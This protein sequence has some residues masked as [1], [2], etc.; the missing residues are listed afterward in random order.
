MIAAASR[1]PATAIGYIERAAA[2]SPSTLARKRSGRSKGDLTAHIDIKRKD[3][4][5]DLAAVLNEA[6]ESSM[7][8]TLT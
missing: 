4:L 2:D 6:L 8:T 1:L 5:G 7:R 3:E